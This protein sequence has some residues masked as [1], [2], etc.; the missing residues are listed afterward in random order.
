[1][2]VINKSKNIVLA[3]NC[4]VADSF[5][6]RFCGLMF[7]QSLA[8]D[9]ALMIKPCNS[10]H[11]MFMRFPIDVLFLDKE[12]KVVGFCDS[13]KPWRLSSLYWGA[14]LAIEFPAGIIQS[15]GTKIGDIV[16]LDQLSS[17]NQQCSE[18]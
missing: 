3:N 9:S 14:V 5:F 18:S 8:L 12:D 2:Q 15:T 6:S 17:Q 10:I 4:E 11:M 1:M 7:R 13:I 16:I